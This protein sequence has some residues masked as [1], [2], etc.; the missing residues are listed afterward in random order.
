MI[1]TLLILTILFVSVLCAQIQYETRAVWV[2]TNFRLDWPPQTLNPD[3]QINALT[4]IFDSIKSKNLNTIYFQVRGNGSVMFNSPFEPYS[5]YLTGNTGIKPAFDPLKLAVKLAHERNLEIHA[6]LNI[7]R[8]YSGSKQNILQSSDRLLNAHPEWVRKYYEDGKVSYWLDPGLPEV[9]KYLIDLISEAI[10]KYDIDGI[11]LDFMRYPGKNFNDLNT[12]RRYGNG[13]DLNDWRRKNITAFLSQLYSSVK[14]IKPYIKVG[15]TPIGIYKN[16]VNARGW[17]GFSEVYQDSETWLKDKIVD[18]LVP[19]IYW[20]LNNNPKFFTVAKTWESI[21]NNR[22]I[23]LGIA[24]YK[25]HIKHEIPEMIDFSKKLN[26]A[27]VALFRYENIRDYNFTN[28]DHWAF[29]AQMHWLKLPGINLPVINLSAKILPGNSFKIK[30]SWKTFD[31]D[32]TKHFFRSFILSGDAGR[33]KEFVDNP[34]TLND[35]TSVLQIPKPDKINYDFH[36]NI[37]DRLWNVKQVSKNK[38]IQ[39]KPLT[40][41]ANNPKPIFRPI[42][43]KDKNGFK[44]ILASGITD[45]ARIVSLNKDKIENVLMQKLLKGINIIEINKIDIESLQISIKA[46][47]KKYKL[48]LKY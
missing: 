17:E 33:G 38:A 13:L 19:Q 47:D 16:S 7:M 15:V 5:I 37:I 43:L 36:L 34:I 10:K 35:S 29:P 14:R 3:I 46:A 12:Y 6:W 2:A 45:T 30:F 23:V 25:N 24:A 21:S 18:Y 42:L 22:N 11:Q 27:G 20:D 32:R 48:N 40:V 44:I 31:K 28:F 41:L 9:R 26:T 4:E 39:Y 8:C 1:K